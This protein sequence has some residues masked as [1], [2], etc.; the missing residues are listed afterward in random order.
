M[1][2]DFQLN[3]KEHFEDMLHNVHKTT[4]LLGKFQN[5]LPR[6]SLLT[7]YKP[8]IRLGRYYL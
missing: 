1:F 6:P 2:L 7:I 4:E 3:F 5:A 8:F